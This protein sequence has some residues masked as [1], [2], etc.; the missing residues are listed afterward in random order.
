MVLLQNKNRKKHTS[1]LRLKITLAKRDQTSVRMKFGSK[2]CCKQLI[3][4]VQQKMQS[5]AA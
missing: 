3:L 1:Y 4:S 2:I 5:S